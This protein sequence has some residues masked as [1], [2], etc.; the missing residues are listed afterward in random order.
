MK[1]EC[2]FCKKTIGIVDVNITEDETISV[3][4]GRCRKC[5]YSQN[6]GG[7]HE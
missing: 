6:T 2:I 5:F 1:V 3:I 7:T 4:L